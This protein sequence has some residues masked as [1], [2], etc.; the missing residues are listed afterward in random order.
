MATKNLKTRIQNKHD[1]EANWAKATT[2]KPLA[3]ELI[4]YDKDSNNAKPR[5]KVGDGTTTVTNLPFVAIDYDGR[6]TS[7][8]STVNGLG[9]AAQKD[10]G[11]FATAVQGT[12]ADNAMPKSGGT[13][14]GNVT[15]ASGEGHLRTDLIK[16]ADDSKRIAEFTSSGLELGGSGYALRFYS[17]TRPVVANQNKELAYTSDIPSIPTHLPQSTYTIKTGVLDK[18]QWVQNEH[19]IWSG[20]QLIEAG[21]E[22]TL[23][24]VSGIYRRSD[25]NT[26]IYISSYDSIAND[27]IDVTTNKFN[28]NYV[29]GEGFGAGKVY[30]YKSESATGN[31]KSIEWRITVWESDII[32][33]Y[34]YGDYV[35]N[36]YVEPYNATLK[37]IT[38]KSFEPATYNLS[39]STI[40]DNSDVTMTICDD[41]GIVPV[42]VSSGK[43]VI[44]RDRVPISDI[45]YSYKVK[46]TNQKGQF[47]IVNDYV[48][49]DVVKK[50]DYSKLARTDGE[51]T[52]TAKQ[53]I[54]S[55]YGTV[56]LKTQGYVEIGASYAH[57]STIGGLFGFKDDGTGRI[58]AIMP[59]D[60]GFVERIKMNSSSIEPGDT[61]TVDLGTVLTTHQTIK[62]LKTNND[63]AQEVSASESISGSGTINLHKVA[64]TGSYNDLLNTPNPV[65]ES[66]VSGWG[67][68]KNTGTVTSVA[69]KMN[70]ATKGTVTSSGTIDLGTVLTNDGGTINKSKTVKMDASSNSDG[71]K[72]KWGTVNSKNPYI[73]Y[74]SDQVDGTFVVGSLLGTNYASGLAIGGGSGN[75][76]WKGAKVAT[77]SDIPS[78]SGKLDKSA[79]SL[80]GTTLTITI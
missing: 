10:V 52:F 59:R 38:S 19:D 33:A 14:T 44:K 74:A 15:F 27:S 69:V 21:S 5:F 64:K 53:T 47:V 12:K 65:T 72:L 39:D 61:G 78:I 7:L 48:A 31:E 9:T 80:S 18:N 77:T 17:N 49:T 57:K 4:I 50:G 76:L 6:I 34:W 45:N 13:F 1:T 8:E 68:T 66:T 62:T 60:L 23:T 79:F 40:T 11:F 67:F 46:L 42:S 3:G 55:G 58:Y 37:Y 28:Y 26:P 63:T 73:G 56:S 51:N 16:S 70:G 35:N 25:E 43:L 75:L 41:I 22:V 29:E 2:F 24:Q 71:A 32:T 36:G 54:N 20:E 30:S